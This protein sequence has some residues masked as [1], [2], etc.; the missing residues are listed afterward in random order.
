MLQK[1][2]ISNDKVTVWK[3]LGKRTLVD[4]NCSCKMTSI[5]ALDGETSVLLLKTL[6]IH[7]N[8]CDTVQLLAG[9]LLCNAGKLE[10]AEDFK[11]VF[12]LYCVLEL[13]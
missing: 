2:N 8:V 1:G 11:C 10:E 9:F 4:I 3:A 5:V 7:V 6:H 12:I 13:K